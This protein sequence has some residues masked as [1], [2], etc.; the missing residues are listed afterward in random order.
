[1]REKMKK[2][3]F[4]MLFLIILGA[5]NVNSQVRIGGNGQPNSAAVLDLNATDAINNGTKGLALPRVSL[6]ALNTPLA[7]SPAVSGMLVYNASGSLSTGV[8]YWNTNQWVKVSDGTFT[9][10]DGIVG[11][12]ITDTIANGGLTRSGVGTA[13]NPYKVGVKTGGIRDGMIAVGDIDVNK[14]KTTLA[15]SGMPLISLGTSVAF[16]HPYG[17]STTSRHEIVSR[18]MAAVSWTLV[19]DTLVTDTIPRGGALTIPYSGTG[20]DMCRLTPPIGRYDVQT[21]HTGITLYRVVF[22]P[23]SPDVPIHLRCY[24]PNV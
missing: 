19:V 14:L 18:P 8:Y 21:T 12:E 13:E 23:E 20:R 9:E 15:D 1:M 7:G 10:A 2:M 11:N 3:L 16:A 5:A 24:R 6:T 22:G 17:L 4:L